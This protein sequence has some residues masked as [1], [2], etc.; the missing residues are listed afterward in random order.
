MMTTAM[1]KDR[2]TTGIELAA[3]D[4][5]CEPRL[6]VDALKRYSIIETASALTLCR[7]SDAAM[8][9]ATHFPD[10]HIVRT[11]LTNLSTT[12]LAQARKATKG[13]SHA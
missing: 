13:K 2:I 11:E 1:A 7:A 4:I 3:S 12:L 8:M 9:R 10:G 6:L 5:G